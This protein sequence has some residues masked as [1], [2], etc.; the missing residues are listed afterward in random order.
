MYVLKGSD[1]DVIFTGD[2]AKNRA[3]LL[4]RRADM[5]YDQG[6]SGQSIGAIWEVWGRRPGSLLVPGHDMPMVVRNGR[7]DYVGKREAAI[8]SWFGDDLE[9]T[10]MFA[11]TVAR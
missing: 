5:S 2:A 10:T 8:R 11:L 9:T 6:V 4:S 1:R 3:E 7:P